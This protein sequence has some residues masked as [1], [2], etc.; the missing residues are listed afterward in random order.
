MVRDRDRL[1][2]LPI[3][4]TASLAVLPVTVLTVL[5]V[6]PLA[7]L[8]LR[9]F[10]LD[11]HTTVKA[12]RVA[13][14][15]WF[16]F[17]QAVVSTLV[18][19]SL[20][21]APA[22]AIA[23]YRFRARRWVLGLV[24]MPFMLPTVVVAAAFMALL[25]T[26]LRE[27]V[28]AVVLAHVFFNVAVVVRLCGT[29]WATIP[30][31]LTAAART[32]GARPAQVFRHVL[33]PL[34][35]PSLIAA[36][37]VVF[38]F[39]FTSFGVVRLLGGPGNTTLEVEI[40]R[41]ATQ[42]GDVRGAALLS[43]VQLAVLAVVVWWSAA[44]QR[45]AAIALRG[46]TAPVPM[47]GVGGRR[48]AA[49]LLV[50]S[51]AVVVPLA[52]LVA[53]SFRPDGRW[54][55]TAWR[56]LGRTEVRPGVGLGVDPLASLWVSLRYAVVASIIAT[57]VGVLAALAISVGHR[58]RW[59]DTGLML[60]LGTSAVTL[61]LGMLITFDRSPFDWRGEWWLV[62]LGH[63]LI[64]IPFVVRSA[65]PSLRAVAP[66]QRA[67]AMTLGASPL[68]AWFEVEIRRVARPALT[69]LG[70]AAAI[71]LGEF[72]ATTFL[73]RAGRETLPIA[74]ARLLGRAGTVPRAQGYALATVLLAVTVVV[75][76]LVDRQEASDARGA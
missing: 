16:S 15:V 7:T 6:W 19:L 51:L 47:R 50:T 57:V 61:G 4:L 71:S 5:Y 45:R 29:M 62:P 64:G 13:D 28:L 26:V 38:L 58:G 32:L 11:S 44:A 74:V 48:A 68:R 56:T 46:A 39:T 42:L 25:P 75:V 10:S 31:D 52:T 8:A 14:V 37:T 59:L 41:R 23:R 9:V 35:R 65:L 3:W 30:S 20:G 24:T 53:S 70:F 12:G 67:A 69:G 60:P 27:G 18:T 76:A 72:G 34:L 2:R 63:A 40:A 66:D 49:V 21:L 33:L 73:S 54:S 17:R 55:L 22:W 43:A 36:A 1:N